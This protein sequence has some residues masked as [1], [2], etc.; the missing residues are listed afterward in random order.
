MAETFASLSTITP[1]ELKIPLPNNKELIDN[2]E[3]FFSNETIKTLEGYKTIGAEAKALKDELLKLRDWY[4]KIKKNLDELEKNNVEKPHDLNKK[5][6]IQKNIAYWEHQLKRAYIFIQTFRKKITNEKLEYII[7]FDESLSANRA[8]LKRRSY[9]ADK[10]GVFSLEE[11]LS[12]NF[13]SIDFEKRDDIAMRLGKH[14]AL[15][16]LYNSTQTTEKWQERILKNFKKILQARMSRR[17]RLERKISTDVSLTEEQKKEILKNTWTNRGFL[18]EAAIA[19]AEDSKNLVDAYVQDTEAFWRGGDLQDGVDNIPQ[20]LVDKYNH[21]NFEVKRLSATASNSIG[22]Q[23][24]SLTGLITA[25]TTIANICL[26]P[27]L[28]LDKIQDF[29][30]KFLFKA[31]K[32]IS[33]ATAN[34]IA[35]IG[36]DTLNSFYKQW[37]G[38]KNKDL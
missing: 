29:I 7:Y 25:L 16:K 10:V 30:S 26:T 32:N 21:S 15:E 36:A 37:I 4:R 11:I 33:E 31:E 1:Q 24:S 35:E 18:A 6:E 27:K 20:E 38:D 9:R 2:I 28:S 12:I 17:K 34:S 5:L 3:Q 23:L 19:L 14:S 8:K 22:A 13:L